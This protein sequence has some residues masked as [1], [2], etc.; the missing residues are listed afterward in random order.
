MKN[1]SIAFLLFSCYCFFPLS[2]IAQKKQI[3]FEKYDVKSGLPESSVRGILEDP[4]GYIW[5][6]T[7][8]GLVRY[9]GY[10]YK[11]YQL[12]SKRTNLDPIS[13]IISIHID[14]Q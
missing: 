8:N 1:F 5:M 4:Q 10:R 13:N 7:Q 2:T 12:G 9:D 6:A 3:Y 11:V 14:R